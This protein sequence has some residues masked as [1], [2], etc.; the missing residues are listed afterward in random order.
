MERRYKALPIHI[1]L[2]TVIILV[3]VIVSGV[4]IYLSNNG[5]NT[6]IKD[7]NDKLFSRVA[8]ETRYKLDSYYHSAF[9]A[10]GTFAK[11]QVA[12][13][14]VA[15][16]RELALAGIVHLL[17]EHPH[18]SSFSFYYPNGDFY[19]V[20]QVK[21]DKVRQFFGID[22]RTR[23]IETH[24]INEITTIT[25]LDSSLNKVDEF[26]LDKK[27]LVQ[28][29]DDFA[30]AKLDAN[31]ISVPFVLPALKELGLTAYRKN[32]FG[33]IISINVSL[34]DLEKTLASTLTAPSSIRA[35]YTDS[36]SIYA[37]SDR[38]LLDTETNGRAMKVAD[39]SQSV[40]SYAIGQHQRINTIETFNFNGEQW[41]GKVVPLAP[42][43]NEPINLLMAT[44][45]ADLFDSGVVIKQQTLY[46]SLLVLL[47]TLPFIYGVS[48]YV[49]Q[50]IRRATQKAQDIER[51]RFSFEPQ[52]PSYIK[53]IQ[54]LTEAQASTQLTIK[55][56]ISLTNNIARKEN[57]DDILSLVCQDIAKAV[58]AQ[59]AFL[60]LLDEETN[61]AIPKC[62]WWEEENDDS[63]NEIFQQPIP[64]TSQ[65]PFV[66]RVFVQKEAHIFKLSDIAFFASTQVANQDAQFICY[67]LIDRTGDVI[68]SFAVMYHQ[69]DVQKLHDKY[70]HY[71]KTLLGFTSVTIE[72]LNMYD[73]QKALL[74]SF[75]QV[76]AGSLD[77]KSP[78][79]GH[80]CQR[81]PVI[82][83][84]LTQAADESKLAPFNDFSLN[85]KE[86]EEL[87]IASWL[88][89]CGKITTPE[90]IVDKATKLECI[91]NR[92][93]EIRMRFE[94]LKR[95]KRLESYAE[96]FGELPNEAEQ[97]L[98]HV[99]T[100]IDED[101]QFI[102]E[103]NVGG[104]FVSD[105]DL[106]RLNTIAKSNWTR[107]LSKRSGT[108]WVEQQ[109]FSGEEIT[110][111][112]ESLLA[113]L[114]EHIVPWETNPPIDER[115]SMKPPQYQANLGELYNLSIRRGTL[116]DEDRF[117][118]NDHIIQT[119][120][121]LESLPFPQHL[122]DVA[123]IAGGHHEKIDGTG[124]P[125]GLKGEDM[126]LT[127]KI[128]AVADV[129]EALTSTD[130]PYKKAKTLKEAIKIM[131]FMA[132]EGHLDQDVFELFLTSGVYQRFAESY[133]LPEQL[134]EVDVSSYV[135]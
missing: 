127:A 89:D 132:K 126:P 102:A 37:A 115:F 119:I 103:L 33:T 1:H 40:L 80:H 65:S 11:S 99:L 108:A 72:T 82:T 124:Y 104:E 39:L 123:R 112:E 78:Y 81:V 17:D 26:E 117:I 34:K 27:L 76:F 101:F 22:E 4:Q 57:V 70:A 106:E 13:S 58:N 125:M 71:L 52:K 93:H 122:K 113:D 67:P 69:G 84:W 129:F 23:Y 114:P 50:P 96:A 18:V 88:H 7:A 74:E 87:R 110:P 46:G 55:Q 60:Y 36:G 73:A 118:I 2:S 98:S 5:L 75:I 92:I 95:D 9:L 63:S 62:L 41:F 12:H 83:E 111:Q 45:A 43:N 68:G 131:S 51:F 44:K 66:Q 64:L 107:T 42:H 31:I 15:Q 90:H 32:S 6:L 130:R 53:E 24:E 105:D 91:Y 38:D 97:K 86:W 59:G 8:S 85:T 134:D 21:S 100:Q 77:K 79:T 3:V 25:G 49:A 128:I 29:H 116:T 61:C 20:M 16:E 54:E 30:D 120:R 94:V 133:M 135:A 121:I 109:R 19:S 47:I 56:F 28:H 14:N 35:L 48:R 10:L